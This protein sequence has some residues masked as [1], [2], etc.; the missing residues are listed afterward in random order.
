MLEADS[1]GSPSSGFRTPS[2]IDL[3]AS[4]FPAPPGPGLGHVPDLRVA[5]GMLRSNTS[6]DVPSD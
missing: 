1:S 2:C 4:R 6:I 3:E 5:S